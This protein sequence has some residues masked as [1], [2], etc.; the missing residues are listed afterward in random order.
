MSTQRFFDESSE[1]PA[2]CYFPSVYSHVNTSCE[3]KNT[4][5]ITA[6]SKAFLVAD[7]CP[8]YSKQLFIQYQCMDHMSLNSAIHECYQNKTVPIICPLLS[9]DGSLLEATAC[10]TDNAPLSLKC[11][12]GQLIDIVCAFYGLHPSIASC[13]LPANVPVCYFASALNNVTV[14]CTGQQA[15]SITFLNTFADPCNGMDKAL[16][17]QYKC[18]NVNSNATV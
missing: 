4:C 13:V 16:Y 2:K 14:A 18:K 8:T 5:L 15:C 9:T 6:N 12:S 1:A 11:P 7:P 3:Y 17:V 10:D